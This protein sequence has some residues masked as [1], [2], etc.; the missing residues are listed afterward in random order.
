MGLNQTSPSQPVGRATLTCPVLYL[1]FLL[2]FSFLSPFTFLSAPFSFVSN[3][4]HNAPPSNPEAKLNTQTRK[5][6]GGRRE[7]KKPPKRVGVKQNKMLVLSLH[8]KI[9][10]SSAPD[11]RDMVGLLVYVCFVIFGLLG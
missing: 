8:P 6:S 3:N 1:V 2:F 11:K 7:G 5:N 4:L 10:F 9:R